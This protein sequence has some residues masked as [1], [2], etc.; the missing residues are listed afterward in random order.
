MTENT[1]KKYGFIVDFNFNR[2]IDIILD[3]KVDYINNSL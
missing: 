1:D 3:I 2:L